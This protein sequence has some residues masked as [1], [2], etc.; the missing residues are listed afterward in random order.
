MDS[1]VLT[2]WA[3]VKSGAMKV[4]A[5]ISSEILS[6]ILAVHLEVELLGYMATF[7][8]LRNYNSI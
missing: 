3:A 5:E 6:I 7:N 1:G 2:V 8:F 4:G